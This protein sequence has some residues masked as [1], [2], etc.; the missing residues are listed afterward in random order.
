[1]ACCS[2]GKTPRPGCEE[3]RSCTDIIFLLIFLIFTAAWVYIAY[4]GLSAGDITRLL[5]GTDSSGHTCSVVTATTPSDAYLKSINPNNY[6][7]MGDTWAERKYVWY[8]MDTSLI[9]SASIP[10]L[11][12]TLLG[13]GV[14]VKECPVPNGNL[15]H[16]VTFQDYKTGHDNSSTTM[17]VSWSVYYASSPILNRCWP[18]I[19][20]ELTADSVQDLLKAWGDIGD[21]VG[22]LWHTAETEV[23][24]AGPMI[25]I[26]VGITVVLALLLIFI[27][28]W[29]VGAFVY[30]V[31]LL[32]WLLFSGGGAAGLWT[33]M[34]IQNNWAADDIAQDYVPLIYFGSVVLL[35]IAL[36]TLFLIIFMFKRIRVAI[37][38]MKIASEVMST[39][40]TLFLV[41]FVTLILILATAGWALIVG[42]YLW[43]AGEITL[44]DVTITIPFTNITETLEVS[45][46][47]EYNAR[48]L[49]LWF[50]LFQ[51]LWTMGMWNAMSFMCIA[52]ATTMFYFSDPHPGKNKKT[53]PGAVC[54]GMWWVFRYHLGTIAFGSFII[55]I[56]QLVRI[57]M[58]K[59]QAQIEQ[60]QNDA[61]K[62]MGRCISCYLQYLERVVTY[63]NKNAY[64]VCCIKS[65][66]FCSS[67][68]T[69]IDLLIG[70]LADVCAANF[71]A[72]AVFI[73]CKL[74]VTGGTV[75]LSWLLLRNT[76]LGADVKTIVFVL[77]LIG[78]ISYIIS[79]IFLHLYDCV[80]DTV[81]MCYCYDKDK[82]NGSEEKPYYFNE[83]LAGIID[84]YNHKSR[85]RS[86]EVAPQ[87]T[88]KD[89]M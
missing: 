54:T 40:P 79:A 21:T 23:I 87:S 64:I 4:L 83:G 39:T 37:E 59:I 35:I 68:Y 14:C 46:I 38:I 61:A 33:A 12:S 20:S 85:P 60:T 52:F 32:V 62:W 8:P 71:L 48:D 34:D 88:S 47:N 18:N 29:T 41:P 43:T 51:F 3:N 1:M 76:E 89:S 10:N 77:I 19:S 73:F 2:K 86:I 67:C 30:F 5:Y 16:P 72:D 53:P 58:A 82:H 7:W 75:V 42:G 65:S 74:L 28:R 22:S 6:T 55:A 45:V 44:S 81:L 27:L 56:I 57:I 80:Q 63:I 31:L 84:K 70:N 69:A 36:I 78:F 49:M 13:L 17:N 26:S 66:N 25:G 15:S 24:A 9:S 50:N 11:V